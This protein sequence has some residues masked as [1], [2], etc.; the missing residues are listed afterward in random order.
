MTGVES[1][2]PL[3]SVIMNCYN[4]ATY[5]KEA[6]DSVYAQTYKHWEIIFWDNASTDQSAVI[7]KSYD[8]KIQYFRAEKTTPLGEARYEAMKQ[9]QGEYIAFLDCDDVYEPEKLSMQID[10]LLQGEFAL[11]YGGYTIIDDYSKETHRYPSKYFSGYLFPNLLS[12]YEICM[13][14]VVLKASVL[15][16]SQLAFDQSLKYCPD[17]KLFLQIAA[18]YPIAVVHD[19]IVKYR[20]HENSL[21]I[22]TMEIAGDEVRRALDDIFIEYSA[23]KDQYPASVKKAYAAAS[24]HTVRYYIYTGQLWRARY[25]VLKQIMQNKKYICVLLLLSTPKKFY[26]RLVKYLKIDLPLRRSKQEEGL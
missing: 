2:Q 23:L 21:S 26:N 22:K 6:I 15:K 3:V 5:L 25:L 12:S 13:P 11:S 24:Y 7:A 4:G 9:A 8:T 17:Y 18:K 10:V 16:E 1:R 20:K 14:S 19:C